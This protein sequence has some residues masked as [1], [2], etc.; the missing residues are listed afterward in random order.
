[1]ASQAD[2]TWFTTTARE[3]SEALDET[4]KRNSAQLK[5]FQREHKLDPRIIKQAEFYIN[6]GVDKL[7]DAFGAR[8]FDMEHEHLPPE[9]RKRGAKF[10]RVHSRPFP[11]CPTC[12]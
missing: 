11:G 3:H 10:C 1:M 8:K 9:Q 5:K 2:I 12:D 7:I 4:K 6:S